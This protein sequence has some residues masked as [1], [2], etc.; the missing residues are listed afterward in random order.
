[1]CLCG[2]RADRTLAL[3]GSLCLPYLTRSAVLIIWAAAV[4]LVRGVP[5]TFA[6]THVEGNRSQFGPAGS[7]V[8]GTRTSRRVTGVMG[9]PTTTS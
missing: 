8:G 3:I 9:M 4:P 5:S 2:Y 1:M 7:A 6:E